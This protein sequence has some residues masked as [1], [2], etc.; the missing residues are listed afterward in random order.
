MRT[1]LTRSI[2]D[3]ELGPHRETVLLN[4]AAALI[5]AGVA[6]G[7]R[8]GYVR[9]KDAIDSGAAANVLERYVELSNRFADQAAS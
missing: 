8:D 2:L 5:A 7:L 4:A 3:G 1:G 9:A 6:E